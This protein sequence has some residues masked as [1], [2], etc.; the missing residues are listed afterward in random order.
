MNERLS[1]V[2]THGGDPRADHMARRAPTEPGQ[3]AAVAVTREARPRA[4]SGREPL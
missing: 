1:A 4:L 2:A 3:A